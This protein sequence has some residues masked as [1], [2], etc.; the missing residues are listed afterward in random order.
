MRTSATLDRKPIGLARSGTDISVDIQD[1]AELERAVV[2]T[3]PETVINCAA[4][5]SIDDCERNPDYAYAVNA[6]AVASLAAACRKISAKLVQVSTDQVYVGA[7]A[8]PHAE[9][10]TVTLINEYARSKFAGESFAAINSDSLVLRTCV[11]GSRH[12]IGAPTFGDWLIDS[13]TKRK[14]LT[15]FTD[16][17]FSPIHTGDFARI[18]FGLIEK[19]YR[20]LLN[21]GSASA[22]SKA[23]FIEMT[24]TRFGIDFDWGVNGSVSTL[25]TPRAGYSAMDCTVCANAL[26]TKMPGVDDCIN[27]LCA[28]R[29]RH[30]SQGDN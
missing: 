4:T 19:D 26:G 30:T 11:V 29:T 16:T 6:R 18:A 24:A 8:S 1:I 23:A 2:E 3:G 12:G 9:T 25:G 14:P 28:E 7:D 21:V 15:I 10:D 13:L 22:V 5:V 27:A 17:A 20:G